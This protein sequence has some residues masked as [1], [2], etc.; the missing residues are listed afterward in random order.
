MV[1]VSQDADIIA[2]ALTKTDIRERFIDYTA[3]WFISDVKLLI[4]HP[5]FIWEYPFVPV[6]PFNVYAWLTNFAAFS[7]ATIFM[8]LVS[9]LNQQEW[10]AMAQRGEAT[11]EQGETF[12]FY[13]TTFYMISIW[14]FQ[15]YKRPP[16]SYAGRVMTG[17]W[18]AYTLMF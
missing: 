2:A 11:Q 3:I 6:F 10:G 8:W 5:S 7:V 16:H 14:A 15:G 4:Q 18:F 13:N 17:F 12:S 1:V 9:R